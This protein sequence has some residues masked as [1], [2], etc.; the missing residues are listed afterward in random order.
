MTHTSMG[1]YVLPAVRHIF[2]MIVAISVLYPL[3]WV[4]LGSFKTEKEF[5]TNPW[6]L[7][8]ALNFGTYANVLT[9]YHLHLNLLNSFFLAAVSTIVV[10]FLSSMLAYGIIRMKWMGS[11]AVLMFVMLGIMVPVHSTLI[12]L[13]IN[14]QPLMEHLD[15]RVVLLLPYIAFG[16]P[17]SVLI[18]SGYFSTLSKEMEEAAVIDGASMIGTF[19]RIILPISTPAIS[20]VS[21]LSFI[22]HWNEL[23]FA[24]VFLRDSEMQTVPVALLQFMG[25]Y[26]TDWSKIL[27][28]ISI[29]IIPSFV[30]Y[31]FLQNRIV[32][33]F[34]A[35]AVKA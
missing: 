12:P 35:G 34:T 2:L 20:T 6:G 4:F 28:S 23:L 16:L 1:K 26:S 29:T 15:N 30:V 18:F 32:Q 14:L 24:L 33:G 8:S 9:Q 19:F 13:Y 7:P 21:I 22:G 25:F 5:Y 27:S 31:A 10:V 17:T 11:K 3:L